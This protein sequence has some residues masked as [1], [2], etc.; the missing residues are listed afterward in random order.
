MIISVWN[1]IGLI[2]FTF[3]SGIIIGFIYDLYR[4]FRGP[5]GKNIYVTYISDILFWILCS[6]IIFVFLIVNNYAFISTYAYVCIALGLFF[7]F[8]IISKYFLLLENKSI[9]FLA[10]LIRVSMKFIVFP[11]KVIFLKWRKFL[12]VKNNN[13]KSLEENS[14][15]N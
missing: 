10:K 14:K 7:Y 5:R 3:A 11:F 12:K 9:G 4:L 6:L 15:S 2:L 8:K 1:E 13:K